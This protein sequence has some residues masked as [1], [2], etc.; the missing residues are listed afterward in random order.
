M[1]GGGGGGR[2]TRLRSAERD[3]RAGDAL[4]CRAGL[5]WGPGSGDEGD[6]RT[7]LSEAVTGAGGVARRRSAWG[8]GRP[9]G[10]R[11]TRPCPQCPGAVGA[12][13][14]GVS[15]LLGPVGRR[16]T[17]SGA[18]AWRFVRPSRG[19]SQRPRP[20]RAV[21]VRA[22]CGRATPGPAPGRRAPGG[23]GAG[24][25]ATALPPAPPVPRPPRS[26]GTDARAAGGGGARAASVRVRA[27]RAQAAWRPRGRPGASGPVRRGR[28]PG[29][30]GN[31]LGEARGTERGR[32]RAG[33]SHRTARWP[34][35]RSAAAGALGGGTAKDWGAGQGGR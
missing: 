14:A 21:A 19:R 30:H 15:L 5:R 7:P 1:R 16:A 25:C 35:A 34:L 3:G 31:N 28:A 13:D 27:A 18:A 32:T 8:A 33:L 10:G 20:P 6:T 17:P 24:P 22:V 2:G 9:R 12:A 26:R 4:G 29:S 23:G 11:V